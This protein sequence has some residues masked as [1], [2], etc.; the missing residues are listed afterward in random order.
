MPTSTGDL[1]TPDWGVPAWVLAHPDCPPAVRAASDALDAAND[2]TAEERA[3][4]DA[5]RDALDDNRAAIAA[6][7]RAGKNPPAPIS[8]E[9]TDER[10]RQGELK[11]RAAMNRAYAAAK[12]Y[13]ASIPAHHEALRPIV[14]ARLPELAATSARAI[15]EA[16][17]AYEEAEGL[18][19]VITGLDNLRLTHRP[20]TVEQQAAIGLHYKAVHQANPRN[21][22]GRLARLG[23]AWDD[24]TVCAT[25]IPADLI[26]ADPFKGA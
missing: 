21:F 19:T 12:V 13:E 2:A 16:R 20:P 24:L 1:V 15:R 5:I 6:A 14:A 3:K 25:R 11:V 10:V 23:M 26:A 18:S 7:I 4:V 9:V 17:A 22:P 8:Q